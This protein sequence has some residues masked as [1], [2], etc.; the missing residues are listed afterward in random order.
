M[1]HIE[2]LVEIQDSIESLSDYIFSKGK[3]N[4]PINLKVLDDLKKVFEDLMKC[5][6]KYK[7]LKISLE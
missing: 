2:G 7:D 6:K 3:K 5:K 4:K 1:Q